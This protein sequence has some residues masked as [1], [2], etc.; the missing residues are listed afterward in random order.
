MNINRY[1]KSKWL[2]KEDVAALSPARRLTVVERFAEEPV[3][4]G[5]ELKPVCYFQGI[6]K[7]WPINT[8]ALEVLSEITGSD[9]TDDYVGA[10]VEIFVDPNVQYQGRR[11]GGIKLRAPAK[12]KLAGKVTKPIAPVADDDVQPVDDA[13]LP[14]FDGDNA[15]SDVGF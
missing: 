2:K 9:D 1:R 6:D 12:G 8:T 5:D 11:V 10:A 13:N 4:E 7:G 14:P 15:D 3:G